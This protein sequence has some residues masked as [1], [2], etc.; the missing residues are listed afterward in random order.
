MAKVDMKV[1]E[2]QLSSS[3]EFLSQIQNGKVDV[4]EEVVKATQIIVE[5]LCG[6][7]TEWANETKTDGEKE[8]SGS[9][10]QKHSI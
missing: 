9:A 7:V 6:T 2:K 4:S 1:I 10:L 5:K 8:K 3:I